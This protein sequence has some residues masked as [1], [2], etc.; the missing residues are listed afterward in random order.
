MAGGVGGGGVGEDF[1]GLVDA[2]RELVCSSGAGGEPVAG[3]R[4]DRG[5]VPG[6]RAVDDEHLVGFDEGVEQVLD[7][8][9]QLRQSAGHEGEFAEQAIDLVTSIR[10][11]PGRVWWFSTRTA[12]AALAAISCRVTTPSPIRQARGSL[13]RSLNQEQQATELALTLWT[14]SDVDGTNDGPPGVSGLLDAPGNVA[15]WTA[16]N[17]LMLTWV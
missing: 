16:C 3:D 5:R 17:A 14:G 4:G 13:L 2:V 11:T 9:Q 1:V 7:L 10:A 6:V 8:A 12:S 15:A